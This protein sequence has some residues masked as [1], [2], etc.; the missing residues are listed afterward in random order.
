[1]T[2]EI[3]SDDVRGDRRGLLRVAAAA[4]IGTVAGSL[5]ATPDAMAVNDDPLLVGNLNNAAT[6]KTLLTTPNPIANDGAFVVDATNADYGVKATASRI[7]VY[8]AAE[9]GVYGEGDVGGAFSG[10]SA[11]VNLVP[12]AS[13]GPP[14][15]VFNGKGDLVVD[16]DG[17]LWFCGASGAPGTWIRVLSGSMQMLNS[18]QRA[19]DSR[20]AQGAIAG[21]SSRSIA[22]VGASDDQGNPM[23]VPPAAVGIVCNITVTQTSSGG[24]LTAY[25]TGT[26]RP[27]PSNLNW[28]Q[29]W[30]IAN[31]AIIKLGTG[32][33]IDIYVDTSSA[34]VIVDVAGY[35]L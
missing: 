11:A 21:G 31:S 4:L 6:K 12:L 14:T 28:S 1:M 8:G 23:L 35:V 30:T 5:R 19:Y 20:N 18:P 26:A 27:G 24:F 25:P 2:E 33:K 17:V 9:F 15:G 22:I 16:S 7:G 13:P 3:R 34:Q 29:G 32:G 10:T